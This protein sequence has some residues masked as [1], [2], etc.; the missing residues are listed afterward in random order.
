MVLRTDFTTP[1]F[2]A[3]VKQSVEYSHDIYEFVVDE[4]NGTSLRFDTFLCKI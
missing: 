1:S 2:R 3:E 4:T